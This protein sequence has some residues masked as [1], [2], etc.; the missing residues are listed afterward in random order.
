MRVLARF[1][2]I[3][4]DM[5]SPE[6]IENSVEAEQRGQQEKLRRASAKNF[7]SELENM[8]KFWER[9]PTVT[10]DSGRFLEEDR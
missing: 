9:F 6:R 1:W 4:K 3:L 8:R 10:T 2:C 5:E 7:Q